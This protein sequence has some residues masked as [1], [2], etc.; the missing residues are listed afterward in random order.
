MYITH[1]KHHYSWEWSPIALTHPSHLGTSLKN[2]VTYK[3][4]SCTRKPL[5]SNHFHLLSIAHAVTA[6]QRT[7]LELRLVGFP[8]LVRPRCAWPAD[9]IVNTNVRSTVFELRASFSDRLHCHYITTIHFDQMTVNFDG[10]YI[11]LLHKTWII[12]QIL[13]GPSYRFR[14]LCTSTYLINNVW[15][16]VAMYC[17]PVR[18]ATT[19]RKIY[20]WLKSNLP[21]M[22]PY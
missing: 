14:T 12:I 8:Y 22:V 5:T 6:M 3:S 17:T 9:S 19:Y 18:S 20:A 10:L 21:L 7:N 13:R 16:T 11:F 15:L 2:S 1:L 4:R